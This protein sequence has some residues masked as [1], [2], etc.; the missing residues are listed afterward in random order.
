MAVS[1]QLRIRLFPPAQ[2]PYCIL[3]AEVGRVLRT[4]PLMD[5]QPVAVHLNC[6]V[7]RPPAPMSIP[8]RSHLSDRALPL[9]VRADVKRIYVPSNRV[10]I[11]V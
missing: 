3:E 6:S 9:S 8:S 2:H 5:A 1:D 11:I 10:A 4:T 7:E